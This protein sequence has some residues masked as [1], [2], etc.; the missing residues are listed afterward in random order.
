MAERSTIAHSIAA[1]A[2]TQIVKEGVAAGLSWESIAVSCETAIS[3]VVAACVEMAGNPDR[4]QFAGEL[5]ETMTERAHQRVTC[6]I[7]G[8]PYEG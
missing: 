1:R 8:S 5:I 3:I 2:G 4:V 6:L 7:R